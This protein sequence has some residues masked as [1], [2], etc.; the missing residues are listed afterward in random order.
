MRIFLVI[1]AVLAAPAVALAQG[2]TTEPAAPAAP[3]PPIPPEPPPIASPLLQPARVTIQAKIHAAYLTT[4]LL[5]DS[6]P[7][8]ISVHLFCLNFYGGYLAMSLDETSR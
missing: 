6:S 4:D 3:L 7:D 1:G 2:Q 8:I 5:V